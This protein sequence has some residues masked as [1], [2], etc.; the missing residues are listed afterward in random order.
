MRLLIILL[1]CVFANAQKIRDIASIIGVRDNQLIG[2]GLVVGLS[3][4][5]DSSSKFTNQTLSNLLKNVN[6]KLDPKD[7]KS[8][9]VAAVIVT[10]T[11]PPFAREGDKLDVTV[12]SIGDAKSLQGGTLLITPLKGVNGKIYALAQ[13]PITMGGFN[14]KGGKGQRHFVTTVKVINGATVERA[15]AWNLYN[16][17]KATL[18]LKKSDFDLAVKVQDSINTYFK[19]Q[20]ATAID[21]R[22][23]VLRKPPHLSMPEFLAMVQ[24]LDVKVPTEPVVVIDERTG[25]VVAG[26]DIKIKPTVIVYGD[27]TIKIAK[28]TSLLD[29]TSNLQ[30]VKASP[31]DII[32]ILENLRKSK[33]L[34]AKIILN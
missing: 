22:T 15:V 10:A 31:Q 25:T 7:I 32:S 3:G 16:Q 28:E 17:K 33:A 2:Y 20:L 18:S 1:L 29:F 12:S 34:S 21:P 9:N 14:S 24:K 4:S 30:K 13:G 6:V 26:S 5:G 19:N 8:K 23:V 27:F 11:L